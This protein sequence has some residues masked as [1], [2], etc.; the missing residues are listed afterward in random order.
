MSYRLEKIRFTR[1]GK[2]KSDR[3]YTVLRRIS[4]FDDPSFQNTCQRSDNADIMSE[5]TEYCI[6]SMERMMMTF[7]P[8]FER[9][10]DQVNLT[11]PDN[12]LLPF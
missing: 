3:V 7:M 5:K 4:W 1:D 9:I 6:A 12:D 2:G 11:F 8:R 10:L